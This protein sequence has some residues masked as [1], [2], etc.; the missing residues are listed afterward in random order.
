MEQQ[1]QEREP[2]PELGEGKRAGADQEIINPRIRAVSK[3]GS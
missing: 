3:V 2:N 1:A